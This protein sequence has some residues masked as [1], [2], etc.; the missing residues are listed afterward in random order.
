MRR[1]VAA[2]ASVF[3]VGLVTATAMTVSASDS[4]SVDDLT[5]SDQNSELPSDNANEPVLVRQ[6]SPALVVKEHLSALNACDL[7]RLMAQYP[8]KAEINYPDGVVLIGREQLRASFADFVKP[9]GQGGLC[10]ITFTPEHISKVGGT[11]NVQWRVDA[12][13][14]AEPYRGSDAYETK[15]GLMYAQVTTFRS[16][17]LKFKP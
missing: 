16:E 10:G 17:D 7:D 14:L 15:D 5:S 12:P 8:N 3:A 1:Y 11:I 13:F 4:V 2:I 6:P 9:Y